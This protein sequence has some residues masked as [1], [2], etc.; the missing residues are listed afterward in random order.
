M[1]SLVQV[2]RPLDRM[3]MC[4]F[5][6]Q[7]SSSGIVVVVVVEV[8]VVVAMQTLVAMHS[9]PEKKASQQS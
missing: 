7:A 9:F 8:V 6:P 4:H 2:Y 3:D 5:L 1:L